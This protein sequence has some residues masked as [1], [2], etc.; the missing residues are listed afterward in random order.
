MCGIVIYNVNV[1]SSEYN[2]VKNINKLKIIVNNESFDFNIGSF[3]RCDEQLDIKEDSSSA[4]IELS[5]GTGTSQLCVAGCPIA[6]QHPIQGWGS[7][8]TP[9]CLILLKQEITADLISNWV[10]M[11]PFWKTAEV[12]ENQIH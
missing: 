7:R 4:K 9:V 11:Q 2:V 5:M 8:N 12:A 6:V 3:E 1:E 10:Q